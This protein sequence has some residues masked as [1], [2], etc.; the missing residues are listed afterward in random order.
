MK[1]GLYLPLVTVGPDAVPPVRR[2]GAGKLP[3]IFQKGCIDRD[4]LKSAGVLF[5]G[6]PLPIPNTADVD[7]DCTID[8]QDLLYLVAYSNGGAA[9]PPGCVEGLAGRADVVAQEEALTVSPNYPNPFNPSTTISYALA[10]PSHV[11][12]NVYNILGEEVATLIDTDQEVG[13]HVV[14]WDGTSNAHTK[15]SSGVYLYRIEGGGVTKTA[16]MLLLK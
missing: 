8:L 5:K 1:L 16:R 7:A 15:V 12:I 11:K 13:K 3:A 6:Q 9:P 4:G 2:R 14:I 10:A